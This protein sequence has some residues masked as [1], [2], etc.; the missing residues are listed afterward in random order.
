MR[1]ILEFNFPRVDQ[2]LKSL[3]CALSECIR[4]CE[5]Q[6][7]QNTENISK[8]KS[9]EEKATFPPDITSSKD[10][11]PIFL[12]DCET[13]IN[14]IHASKGDHDLNQMIHSRANEEDAVQSHPWCELRHSLGRLLSYRRASEIICDAPKQWPSLFQNFTVNYLTSPSIR[15]ISLPRSCTTPAEIVRCAFPNLGTSEYESYLND[16][17]RYRLDE[18]IQ[19]QLSLGVFKARI[20]CE[21]YLHSSLIKQ[22]KTQSDAFWDGFKFIAT[23]KPTCCLCHYYFQ[24]E[25]NNDFQVQAPHMNLYMKWLVPNVYEDEGHEAVERRE[26]VVDGIID[27]LMDDTLKILKS[28]F[29]RW[30]TNDSRTDSRTDPSAMRRYSSADQYDTRV[31]SGSGH[32]S[33]MERLNLNNNTSGIHTGPPSSTERGGRNSPWLLVEESLDENEIDIGARIATGVAL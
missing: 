1:R 14:A 13:L 12:S 27:Q 25:N 19:E 9:L 29:P 17:Q 15:R 2:Y 31:L 32:E 11:K 5:S 6:E 21:V 16:L 3:L 28:Q 18:M 10:S 33:G 8:L 24:D 20:H 23:S 4:H 7:P 22:G 26:E 30:K